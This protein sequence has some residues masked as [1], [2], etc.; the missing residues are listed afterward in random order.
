MESYEDHN[1]FER[2][3]SIINIP[4]ELKVKELEQSLNGQLNGVLYEDDSFNDGDR[5]KIRAEKDGDIRIEADGMSILYRVPL[6]LW[7]Q[8]NVGVGKVEATGKLSLEFRTRYRIDPQWKLTTETELESY[9]W[10]QRPK[11]RLGVVSLP[12]ESI[13][14]L[15]IRRGEMSISQSIDEMVAESFKLEEYVNEAWEQLFT[16]YQISEEYRTWLM[17]NPRDIG[18][19]PIVTDNNLMTA[20]IIVKS[21]PELRFGEEP[22]P[23]PTVTLPDFAYRAAPQLTESGFQVFVE[24]TLAYQEAEAL[25]KQSLV[26]ER[27]EQGRR[28]VVVEDIELYGRGNNL[29]VNLSLSG[30]YEGSIFLTGEP[31]FNPQRNRI[32]IEDLEYTIDSKNFL[33]RSAAWLAKGTLKKKLQENMDYL[34][35]YNIQDARKQMQEQL[36]GYQLAPGI[37]L[38]GQLDNVDLYNAYLTIDGIRVAVALYG[39][40][41][42]LVDGLADFNLQGQE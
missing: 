35:D 39:N 18:M 42:I 41:A 4:I 29:V 13:A 9:D 38:N 6:N 7:I 24:A 12:I 3:S 15:I 34:L 25:T 30:S 5:M 11:A 16:P 28:H 31:V 2:R 19:T 33:L 26:G 23:S 1:R 22:T 27:F 40:V 37:T 20:T 8:Y 32:E 17:V 14:N 21:E 36:N 10:T